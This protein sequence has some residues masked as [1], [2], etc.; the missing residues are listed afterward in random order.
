MRSEVLEENG[1]KLV[2]N[3]TQIISVYSFSGRW[4]LLD[5]VVVKINEKFTNYNKV[6]ST[7]KLVTKFA[8][9]LPDTP[10]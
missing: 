9:K 1:N 10:Q 4:K 7:V 3:M 2:K 8:Q 6:T 5:I